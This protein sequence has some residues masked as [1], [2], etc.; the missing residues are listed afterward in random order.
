MAESNYPL[1]SLSADEIS[2]AAKLIRGCH[3]AGTKL[4]FKGITLHEPS[5]K[6]MEQYRQNGSA[7]TYLPS[8]KS[9]INYYLTG[10]SSFFKAIVN[11]TTKTVESRDE[12]PAG[13]HGPADGA[14]ILMVEKV[15]LE[16]PRTKA[17]IEKLKLPSGA[18]VVCDPWIW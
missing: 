16:D 6:E 2:L 3:D 17:E 7:G 12:V 9:W 15:A 14:E 5:K 4:N 10:T 1:S 8:R 18:V 13:F 11:L